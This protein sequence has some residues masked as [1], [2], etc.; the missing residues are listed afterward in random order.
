MLPSY[1]VLDLE[2]TGGSATGDFVTEIAAVRI[3]NGQESERWSTLV[4]PGVPIPYFIQN[5]TGINDAMVADAPRF[6]H[7]ADKLLSLLEGSVLVA[8]RVRHQIP[9]I[10]IFSSAA[11]MESTT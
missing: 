8:P 5:L 3:D 2:T 9:E 4:N 6:K 7:L 10:A 11:P 1:V